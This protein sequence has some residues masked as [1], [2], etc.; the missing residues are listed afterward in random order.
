MNPVRSAR[1]WPKGLQQ[2]WRKFSDR[3]LLEDPHKRRTGR[4]APRLYRIP[5][6][7]PVLALLTALAAWTI[8]VALAR[9]SGFHL[10]W[11]HPRLGATPAGNR[12]ELVRDTLGILALYGALFAAIYAYRKQRVE[13]AAGYRSDAEL[14]SKRY[15][16]AAEQIGHERAAVR[17]AGVYAMARLVDDW[18]DQRQTCVDVLCAYLRM[19]HTPSSG[20]R[21]DHSEDTVR[22][23]ILTVISSHVSVIGKSIRWSN[24]NFDL[25]GAHLRDVHFDHC[26]FDGDVDFSGS[27]LDGDCV[28]SNTTFSGGASFDKSRIAG[29]VRVVNLMVGAHMPVSFAESRIPKGGVFNLRITPGASEEIHD[30][31]GLEGLTIEGDLSMALS[32]SECRQARISM[33]GTVLKGGSVKIFPTTSLKKGPTTRNRFPE[34]GAWEWKVDASST[35][36][37]DQRFIDDGIVIWATDEDDVERGA[38]LRFAP[39]PH[40]R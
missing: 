7:V 19:P 14:L 24:L 4:W 16:D 9:L 11:W 25:S 13:E 5:V 15:Q 18:E 8:F 3:Y 20:D 12:G 33:R 2:A 23:T 10:T 29:S 36:D 30:K 22:R 38:E 21:A 26:R 1:S 17:L 32:S 35:V 6:I 27:T 28:F 37:I 39:R 40:E 34:V 31:F